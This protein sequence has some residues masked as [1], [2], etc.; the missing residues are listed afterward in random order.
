MLLQVLTKPPP[1]QS[2]L[3][4]ALSARTKG[5][6]KGKII[7]TEAGNTGKGQA[8]LNAEIEF[9]DG[10]IDGRGEALDCPAD[11]TSADRAFHLTGTQDG[12]SV[13]FQIWF[14]AERLARAP[15]ICSGEL[16][17]NEREMAGSWTVGC[18]DPKECGCAGGVGNFALRRVD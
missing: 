15:F 10:V 11:G 2:K 3:A 5:H 17:E 9:V 14:G 13:N 1:A 18:F 6:W 16:S 4:P 7:A 12:R 8:T